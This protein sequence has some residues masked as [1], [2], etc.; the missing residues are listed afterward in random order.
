MRFRLLL[1]VLAVM[2]LSAVFGGLADAGQAFAQTQPPPP[3]MPPLPQGLDPPPTVYPP[4]E[5]SKGSYTYYMVCMACHGDR[6]QGLTEEWRG[7]L[8]VEDQNCWQSKCHHTNYPPGGFVFP[9]FVPAV[10]G[11]IMPARFG[12]GLEL[13]EYLHTEM[14]FQAPGSL[15]DEEYWQLTA[16]LLALNGVDPGEAPL[17][18]ERAALI[19]LRPPLPATA[20]PQAPPKDTTSGQTLIWAGAGGLIL[21]TVSV[22]LLMVWKPF[23]RRTFL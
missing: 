4:T 3:E 20:A 7:A 2:V 11:P 1:L 19:Y 12:T 22:V 18:P 8:D 6:G 23:K 13:Y 5:V 15:S 9:K 14:P 17:N 10:I 16:F 21:A